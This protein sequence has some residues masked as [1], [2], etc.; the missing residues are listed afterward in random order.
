MTR[1]PEDT[2]TEINQNEI[3]KGKEIKKKKRLS[4]S[5]GSTWSYTY[6]TSEKEKEEMGGKTCEEI[7]ER[8]E[9][10]YIW[11]K[12]KTVMDQDKS[13]KHKENYRDFPG[14]L[15]VKNLCFHWRKGEFNH[16]SSS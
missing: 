9:I 15:A 11:W 16:W 5:C 8:L 3:Q 2:A 10:L 1:E 4:I 6:Y 7:L 13:K 14:G 12:P